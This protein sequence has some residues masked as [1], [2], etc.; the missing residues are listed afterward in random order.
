MAKKKNFIKI[1]KQVLITATVAIF[2][3]A[4]PLFIIG[5]LLVHF[6]MRVY[7]GISINSIAV[8]GMQVDEAEDMIAE[9]FRLPQTITVSLQTQD[10]VKTVD[11]SIDEL[12]ATINA[13]EQIKAAYSVGRSGNIF[14]DVGDIL[15]TAKKKQSIPLTLSIDESALTEY[16]GIIASGITNPPRLPSFTLKN[17]SASVVQAIAGEEL[18]EEYARTEIKNALMSG[19]SSVTLTTKA[20]DLTLTDA[21]LLA[22]QERGN[23]MLEKNVVFLLDKDEVLSLKADKILP[24]MSPRGGYDTAAAMQLASDIKEK[25]DRDMIEP[26]FRFEHDRVQE[27]SPGVKGVSVQTDRLLPL[28]LQQ[29]SQLEQSDEQKIT[30]QI[31]HA[32]VEPKTNVSDVNN[33]GIKELLG[34]G[35]SRFAGSIPSRVFNVALASSRVNGI[36]IPPGETFSFAKAVGDISKLTGYKEAYIIQGGKTILGDG[37]GV[38][39]VSTTLFRAA[40]NAGLPIVER[41]AHAYRVGYYE[42]GSGP[43]IDATVYVPSV[44]FKFKNDTAHHILVQTKVDTKNL[45]AE[46]SIY[47]TSDG[48]VANVG[49]PVVTNQ[50]EPAEDQYI[51]DPTLPLGKLNHVEHK[52]WGA[53]VSFNYSVTRNGETIY[54]KTFVSTYQPWRNVFMRG[55]G[56]AQ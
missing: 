6:H 31:P 50:I 27:F 53:R 18:P 16:I 29:I 2:L 3:C 54:E 7:P 9:S 44:D 20:V 35:T 19:Q 56:P 25:N 15:I 49:K 52:A 5:A 12:H 42:Q 10:G 11:A 51:D 14:R 21:E 28:I 23:R 37:G 48:R 34:K 26:V 24:L 45:T 46:F 38:C 17:G 4:T 33:L 55:T 36:L 47:G 39:Q 1:H 43:G 32:E 40:L 13:T 30:I 22:A 41:R 8:G